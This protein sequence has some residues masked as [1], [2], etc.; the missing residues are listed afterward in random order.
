M[1]ESC[2]T[3]Q[4]TRRT[5]LLGSAAWRATGWGML[6]A[7]AVPDTWRS[8]PTGLSRDGGVAGAAGASVGS[9]QGDAVR[10]AA[11]EEF[12]ASVKNA[13]QEVSEQAIRGLHASG[14]PAACTDAAG[15]LIWLMPDGTQVAMTDS[16]RIPIISQ[17]E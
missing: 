5:L 6:A 7:A 17:S 3:T 11:F 9:A 13:L 16:S 14:V 15:H 4:P 8:A 10:T 2:G 1:T 12:A